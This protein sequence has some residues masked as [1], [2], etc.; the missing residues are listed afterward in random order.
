MLQKIKDNCSDDI[1]TADISGVEKSKLKQFGKG[2]GSFFGKV[3]NVVN[4]PVNRMSVAVSS[5]ISL[6]VTEKDSTADKLKTKWNNIK[7]K[8]Q[9]LNESMTIFMKPAMD[10]FN[11]FVHGIGENFNTSQNP[12]IKSIRCN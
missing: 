12:T 8:S 6:P 7:E 10:K 11:N 2:L 5:R 4:K 9:K 3:N 1:Q